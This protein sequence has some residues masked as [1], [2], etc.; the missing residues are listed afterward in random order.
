M[1]LN[2]RIGR[3]ETQLGAEDDACKHRVVLLDNDGGLP[4]CAF[5]GASYTGAESWQWCKWIPAWM[6]D[7]V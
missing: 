2:G 3:L 5:C 1:N 6:W 4:H 7:A